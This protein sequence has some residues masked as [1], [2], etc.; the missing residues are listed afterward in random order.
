MADKNWNDLWR[1]LWESSASYTVGD[2]V[3]HNGSSYTCIANNTNQE[4]PNDTFWALIAEKG[5]TGETGATGP[6][7]PQG[8]EGA[9]PGLKYAFDLET[10]DSDPGSG[11]LRL[12]N[13]TIASATQIYIDNLDGQAADVSDFI[14]TWDDSTNPTIKGTII[15]RKISAKENY[16]IFNVTGSVTN[17]TDYRKV[18]VTHVD[19][20]GSFSD[21]DEISVE[22]SRTGNKGADG[23]GVGDVVG[24]S[25]SVDSEIVLFDSTT[26][27]LIKSATGSGIVKATSGVY[28]TVT[29]PTGAIVGTTDT[30][31]LTNKTLTTPKVD[32]I[33][34]ETADAGVTVD[35]L[36]IKDGRVAGW[37]GWMPANETWTYAS[38][39]DPTFTITVPSGAAS[40]YSEGMRIKLTQTT[41]K[42]FIITKVADTVLTVYGGTDY[43]LVD[44]AITSP[45]YSTQKAP[46]GFPLD[47]TKWTIE[48]KNTGNCSQSSPTAGTWYNLGSINIAIPIGVWRVYYQAI[49]M[50]QKANTP[51]LEMYVT[52]STA[53]NSQS[54]FDFTSLF[55]IYEAA[56]GGANFR[57]FSLVNREKFLN[58]ASK[59]TYY[60]NAK[61]NISG[62]ITIAFRG[63]Q[64][65]TIIRAVCAYL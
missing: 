6:T 12:N 47:P 32:V 60:L 5:D 4:P 29:A 26:G 49:A 51:D 45:Y 17:A 1:G 57:T 9:P 34:E 58:L 55:S 22:F 18:A 10:A 61:T 53:N 50:P 37:D 36:K 63:D 15:I 28:S 8:P 65:P 48:T 24:P 31:I 42:Y 16:A 54:D 30:Q 3:D 35:G 39:D 25:S 13:A 59:T 33:N 41:D 62:M 38:A 44:A 43:D 20:N 19:S 46:L 40:K 2:F 27:K 7:G 64:A 21:G 23:T 52:L 14:D 56:T 11:N